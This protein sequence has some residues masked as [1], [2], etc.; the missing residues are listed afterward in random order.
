MMPYPFDASEGEFRNE[1]KEY[2]AEELFDKYASNNEIPD[3]VFQYIWELERN[4]KQ[5]KKENNECNSN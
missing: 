4:I 2:T 3:V 1:V 5:L